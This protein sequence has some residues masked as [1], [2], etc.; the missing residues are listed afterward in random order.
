MAK[1]ATIA[2]PPLSPDTWLVSDTHWGHGNII[3]YSGR[4][5][6]H[7]ERML[8]AWRERVRPDDVVIHLGD[9]AMSTGQGSPRIPAFANE[10]RALPGTT[11]LILGNHDGWTNSAVQRWFG[12]QVVTPLARNALGER[13]ALAEV[14]GIRV[15]LSHRP[16][17]DP[18]DREWDVNIHG[19]IHVNGWP[20]YP[21]F[22]DRMHCNVS[23]EVTDYGPVRLGDVLAGEA[24]EW[25]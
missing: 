9:V 23:V 14:D 5:L 4:P 3:K 21:E 8:A 7:N 25:R 13:R 15:A 20:G 10:I 18:D 19:H 22:S 16:L 24:G 2:L 11:Y 6:D 12:F 17:V 1:P